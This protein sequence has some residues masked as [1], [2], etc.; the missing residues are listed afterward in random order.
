MMKKQLVLWMMLV[1]MIGCTSTPKKQ[2]VLSDGSKTVRVMTYN[3]RNCTG[4]DSLE[5]RGSGAACEL[6]AGIIK[7]T[8]PDLVAV[9]ELDSMTKRN[10]G[11]FV[12]EE[13]AK[14]TSLYPVYSPSI[15]FQGGKY[16]IGVLSKEK[17]VSSRRIALPGR[18]EA[19]SLLVVEYENYIFCCTHLSLTAEDQVASIPLIESELKEYKKP[20][21]LAG[22]MNSEIHSETQN[23]LGRSF[24]MLNDYNEMTIPSHAPE[25]CIDFI[26]GMKNGYTYDVVRKEVL[27]EEKKA[28]DHLPVFVDVKVK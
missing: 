6:V 16:G 15:E 9:Q 14:R 5:N 22:D 23:A 13:L 19:R 26:Y 21:F 3:V 18:E 20:V 12:L 25:Q 28:S 2:G 10:K 8:D 17:P 1:G 27:S 7:N 11:M 4:G 24:Q